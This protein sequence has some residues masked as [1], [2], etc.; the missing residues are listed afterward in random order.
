LG[1]SPRWLSCTSH[2]CGAP[3]RTVAME[4]TPGAGWHLQPRQRP[5]R[6]LRRS[7]AALV[8]AAA[9]CGTLVSVAISAMLP[10]DTGCMA[11]RPPTERPVQ[12]RCV[13]V[14]APKIQIVLLQDVVNLGK[15]G[16]LALVKGGYW[17]N[18]LYPRG[19]AEKAEG[20]DVLAQLKLQERNAK[21]AKAKEKALLAAQQEQKRIEKMKEKEEQ[22]KFMEAKAKIE[23]EE[24]IFEKKVRTGSNKIYGSISPTNLAEEI[25]KKSGVPV[26]ITAV[27]V[28]KVAE[29]GTFSATVELFKGVTAVVPFQVIEEGT[30]GKSEDGEE[31]DGEGEGEGAD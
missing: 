10:H 6:R 11:Y 15:A 25:A 26:R 16:D 12:K 8:V 4:A 2:V 9:F 17:R 3:K 5:L 18:Y 30:G 31:G 20:S 7:G 1:S 29:T 21:G 22:S 13:K 28:P 27:E 23:K 19:Y 14:P 24:Y